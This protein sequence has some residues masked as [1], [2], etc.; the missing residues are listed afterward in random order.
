M[1]VN[2][3]DERPTKM[4]RTAPLPIVPAPAEII[5]PDEFDDFVT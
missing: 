1:F 4:P 3:T 5:K 2:E